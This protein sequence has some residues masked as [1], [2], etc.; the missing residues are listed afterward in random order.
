MMCRFLMWLAT[1][2]TSGFIR[3]GLVAQLTEKSRNVTA[4]TFKWRLTSPQI[5]NRD[6]WCLVSIKSGRYWH[7]S[8]G[9]VII[10]SELPCSA[11][12]SQWLTCV[13][14]PLWQKQDLWLAQYYMYY[15]TIRVENLVHWRKFCICNGYKEIYN[16]K[17]ILYDLAVS[18]CKWKSD[19]YKTVT[20]H[21][22]VKSHHDTFQKSD[23]QMPIK[24]VS[25]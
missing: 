18:E 16:K 20:Q 21:Y 7:W 3:G 25:S 12:F 13:W 15:S 5:S 9:Q 2:V 14:S 19:R 24:Q 10:S 11:T 6:V 4:A 22:L 1:L 17:D 23:I 8:G